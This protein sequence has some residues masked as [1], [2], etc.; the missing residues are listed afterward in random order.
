MADDMRAA[1]TPKSDQ[2][3]ADD[4]IVGQSITIKIRKV[5]V[6]SSAEQK[7][8]IFFD[9]DENKPYKPGKSMSRVLAQMW[10]LDSSKYVGKYLTLYK[11]PEVT[12]AG[13]KVGGLRISHMSDIEMATSLPLTAS[14]GN[15]KMFT[16]KP[17]KINQAASNP[18]PKQE[19]KKDPPAE[20]SNVAGPETSTEENPVVKAAA[21]IRR[22]IKASPDL[23]DLF[24]IETD[25]APEYEII[26]ANPAT[27][28][29]VNKEFKERQAVLESEAQNNG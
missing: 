11:D 1:I 15:K 4:L 8:S 10:G 14:K 22:A 7:V 20:E 21:K 16:V 28:E 27:L 18:A 25:F 26:N 5:V 6:A 23:E 13:I 24:R 9:G 29:F 19:P 12:W 3:N 17:L 2:L